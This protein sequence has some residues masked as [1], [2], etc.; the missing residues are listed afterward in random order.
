MLHIES[1]RRFCVLSLGD[2]DSSDESFQELYKRIVGDVN[3]DIA[4]KLS[5][6]DLKSIPESYLTRGLSKRNFS[7]GEIN[8]KSMAHIMKTLRQINQNHSKLRI[9]YDLGSGSGRSTLAG[10]LL[11][12]FDKVV[13]I[14]LLPSLHELSMSLR[15]SYNQIV[16]NNK[17]F[18][19]HC[20]SFLDNTMWAQEADVIFVNSTC[21]DNTVMEGISACPFKCGAFV[22]TLTHKLTDSCSYRLVYETRLDT[23]WGAAD[24]FIHVIVNHD[25]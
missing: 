3:E 11:F 12:D 25:D 18:E 21:F 20:R 2:N 22:I 19:F 15:D 24:V 10:L 7:Y 16:P 23:S 8:F 1:T 4:H 9:F 5:C 6:N 14:E 17:V 13:G